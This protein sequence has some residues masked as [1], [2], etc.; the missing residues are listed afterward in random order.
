MHVHTSLFTC[1]Q[2]AH[3]IRILFALWAVCA[4]LVQVAPKT[5]DVSSRWAAAQ[6][7]DPHVHRG[8]GRYGAYLGMSRS[9]NLT[10]CMYLPA[11]LT[12]GVPQ[13]CH[14]GI[15]SVDESHIVA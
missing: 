14:W 15:G 13:N 1:Y 5:D 9:V 12:N 4:I 3:Q 7:V 11:F 10:H 2:V 6:A 8:A